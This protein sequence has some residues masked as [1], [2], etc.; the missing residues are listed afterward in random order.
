MF[1]FYL[2]AKN[3]SP[4]ASLS[5]FFTKLLSFRLLSSNWKKLLSF[6]FFFAVS[7]EECGRTPERLGVG[8]AGGWLTVCPWGKPC[9]I[10]WL[11]PFNSIFSFLDLADQ[12]IPM[13]PRPCASHPP[14]RAHTHGAIQVCV[15]RGQNWTTSLL[16]LKHFF[17]FAL[18]GFSF[19][20]VRELMM[21]QML[22]CQ[23]L[24]FKPVKVGW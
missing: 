1:N 10:A 7:V 21:S 5:L 20:F 2:S 13:L 17:S 18:I 15:N 3:T 12:I 4:L 6:F 19:Y 11:L 9:H 24:P 8:P 14:T 16:T 23:V 22:D